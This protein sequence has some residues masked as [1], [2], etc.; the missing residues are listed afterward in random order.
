MAN[1]SALKTSIQ[2][3]IRNNGNQEITGNLLQEILMSMVVTMGDGAIN[4]NE[5]DIRA[6]ETALSILTN[7]L[8]QGYFLGGIA[9]PQTQPDSGRLFYLAFEHGT[10]SH[11]LANGDIPITLAKD[12][13][14]V[15]YTT[16]E[17]DDWYYDTLF[18]V[19]ENPTPNSHNLVESGGIYDII[20]DISQKTMMNPSSKIDNMFYT[21]N[22]QTYH[23]SNSYEVWKYRVEAGKVYTFSGIFPVIS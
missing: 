8:G 6:L 21:P 19:D 13:F 14:Y 18:L 1:F 7:R 5:T 17:V 15:L 4:D 10:Y 9:T 3:A 16:G 2:A 22:N 11:F 20:K 12:G 23:E